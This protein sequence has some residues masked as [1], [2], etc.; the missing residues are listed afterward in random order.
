MGLLTAGGNQPGAA[1]TFREKIMIV[2][3]LARWC[4]DWRPLSSF[5]LSRS[6]TRPHLRT[7]RSSGLGKRS[8][9]L[10]DP[11]R[12]F[13]RLLGSDADRPR[14]VEVTAARTT[15]SSRRMSILRHNLIA[16]G[17]KPKASNGVFVL[18]ARYQPGFMTAQKRKRISCPGNRYAGQDELR[19]RNRGGRASLSADP[20]CGRLLALVPQVWPDAVRSTSWSTSASWIDQLRAARPG[21]S[22]M[23]LV[24]SLFPLDK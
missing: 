8:N 5:W 3:R 9:R 12:S 7:A 17:P 1:L 2:C 13:R 20:D 21:Y 14:A 4:I 11:K 18:Q 15:T 22:E 10:L 6:S 19:L 16:H 24:K 23:P